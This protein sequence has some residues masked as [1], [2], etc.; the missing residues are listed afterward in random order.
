MGLSSSMGMVILAI[1]FTGIMAGLPFAGIFNA[2]RDNC[3]HCPGVAMGFVN[4]W[5]AIGVMI[6]PPI[7]GW[8]VDISGTFISGFFVM[9]AVAVIAALGCLALTHADTYMIPETEPIDQP[10]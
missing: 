9:G 7:I 3:P 8:L 4:T 1:I 6:F 10:D 2:A 5:G